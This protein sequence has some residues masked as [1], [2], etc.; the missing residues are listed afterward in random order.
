M[1]TT[2]PTTRAPPCS[3]PCPPSRG[4]RKASHR[5][6]SAQCMS[7]STG[8][9]KR[10]CTGGGPALTR[11]FVNQKVLTASGAR[12]HSSLRRRC[13][14]RS[15]M[16][17]CASPRGS[18]AICSSQTTSTTC[19]Y[20]ARSLCRPSAALWVLRAM[21]LVAAQWSSPEALRVNFSTALL[22]M[23]L[24]GSLLVL[25][26]FLCT[27]VWYCWMCQW[28]YT[29]E[30]WVMVPIWVACGPDIVCFLQL[31]PAAP[32]NAISMVPLGQRVNVYLIVMV[33]W[34]CVRLSW[35]PVGSSSH[36]VRCSS[37]HVEQ[38]LALA[39]C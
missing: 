25:V 2:S 5:I 29:P 39:A 14:R 4:N 31:V 35:S 22:R 12:W 3:W 16:T 11:T 32:A 13:W 6:W 24:A 28:L 18:C 21:R 19:P 26:Q 15:M 36:M 30:D 7:S 27:C 1:L 9:P 37:G 10:S 34:I 23:H 17:T 20:Q 33:M 8:L 38:L